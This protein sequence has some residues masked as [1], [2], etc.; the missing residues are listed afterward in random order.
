M[1][2]GLRKV[3]NSLVSAVKAIGKKNSVL[4]NLGIKKEEMVDA[5]GNLKSMT[6]IMGVLQKHTESMDKTQKNAVFNSLFG[7]TGQQAGMIL[8]ENSQRLGELTQK[9]QE[10][11]DKGKYVQT[12]SE[13]NSET[14]QANN[15]KFKKAWEDLEIKFGAEL[16]PYMTEATRKLGDL[17]GQKDFQKDIKIMA[18]GVG[19][20]SKLFLKFTTVL[21]E[22]RRA[23]LKAGA[24]IAGLLVVD[25]VIN[26]T[27]KLKELATVFG[28]FGSK[29]AEEQAEV[30]ALTL[31]Y[32]S[33]AE[34]KTLASNSYAGVGSS[35][36]GAEKKMSK[37][38]QSAKIAEG[39]E[40]GVATSGA[41]EKGV[42]KSVAAA[43]NS[44]KLSSFMCRFGTK[45]MGLAG[46]AIS[47]YSVVDDVAKAIKTGSE[48]SKVKAAANVAGTAIGAGV[49]FAAGGPMGAALGSSIG[50]MLGSTSIAQKIVKGL[51]NA[52]KK[53]AKEQQKQIAETGYVMYDGTMVKVG[54]V[55]IEKSSL[56]KAQKSVSDDIRK[57]MDKADLS[58]IKMSVQTDDKSL[59][60][61][62][63]TLEGFYT[64]IA[65]TAEKQSQKRADAEKRAVEQMYK[66]HQISKKQYEEYI[67]GI[68]DADKKRQSSQKKTYDSL[69]KATNKYNEDLKTATANGQG[70]VNRITYTYNKKREKLAKDEAETI[71]GVRESGY[72]EIK[73]RTYTG[74]EA[75][76]KVQEQFKAKREKL[77]KSEKKE[78]A[79][80]ARN[81]AN[82]KKKITEKYNKERLSKLQSL[83][84]SIAKEMG[85]SSKQQKEIL[86]KLR[87]DKGQISDNEARDLINKS[88]SETKKLIEHA[89][90]TR[91]ET[92]D[93]AQQTYKGKVEQYRRMNKDIPGYTRDMMNKDIANAKSER[94]TTVSVAN[95]AKNKIVGSAKAKHNQVVDEAKKQNKSVS[96]NI[97]AEG[98]NGIKSYNAWGA[99]VHNTL[100]F[101]SDAWSSVVHAFGGSYRGNVGSYRPA[102]RIGSYANGGVARTGLALVGEAGPE[103]V[104]TPWSK[105]ARIV[106]R[107]GAEVAPLN[108]GEQV[109]NARDTARV[110]TGSYSGTLPGYAT[111]TF[112]LSGFIGSI[113]DKALDIADSV[114]DVLKKPAEWIAKG[115]S[116]WPNVQ[117]FSFTHTT[118]MDQTRDMAKK[119]LTNPVT[120][121][122]KKLLKSYDDSGANPGGSGV[123]RWEPYVKKALAKLGLSTSS[124]MV[125]KVLRQIKTESGGNPH[126]KQPGADPDGDGSGPALG[127]MQTKRSTF[128]AYALAGHK[129]IWNGYDNMLAGLNYAR[130]RYGASLSALGKGHGYANGGLVSTHGVYEMAE[131]NLPEMVI[132]LDLS[133]RSRAYQLMQ[134][135][136][137]YFAR[138]DN[139]Q[140]VSKA[141]VESEKSNNRL[142]QT[143]GA[144]LTMLTKLFGASEEQIE[145]LRTLSSGNDNRQLADIGQKLDA[146]ANKQLRVDGSSFARS[147]EQY[148]SVERNRRD[149]MLGRGMSIDTR[150]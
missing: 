66:Q 149:T 27:L 126:A 139:H 87:K 99:A 105:S 18:E 96:Q 142:E 95:E 56:T 131:Q 78:Q 41:V 6:D 61:A 9:T 77:A 114:L 94:D 124:A 120:Q 32:Q 28:G 123:K 62:K 127:L 83:S 145:V 140:G 146:I 33:L 3:I 24:A 68:N 133:K 118:L 119:S 44:S 90:K 129:D 150:I 128:N 37:P 143:L 16:L 50:N 97:V 45:I 125:N 147:Y 98:N 148:G 69:I 46:V 75:V 74:E 40:E 14:A 130:T 110:M 38:V 59:N 72:V 93:K 48:S 67:K 57:S 53:A 42:T 21:I 102:A 5:N 70:N 7:T 101:L 35:A 54:K 85:T 1:G 22:N 2:T 23:V 30:K 91:K 63:A 104:Y 80:I 109:L 103:L 15:Q 55:K 115:F 34:A 71:K 10:A 8:A 100:K 60:K 117:A 121:A 51:N 81:T 47:L 134:K 144:M 135:S 36:S 26:F 64:S 141:D 108:Q 137:D 73:G 116:H 20:V 49:G 17:F 132:P 86:E 122:F 88:A 19:F 136:L 52:V 76:R 4:D 25:K 89:E 11:A 43:E 12:L 84:K 106:G 107:H 13:K 79:E 39:I 58:V 92:V 138:T 112:S 113:K 111:G 82:E 31:E 29:V 65:R